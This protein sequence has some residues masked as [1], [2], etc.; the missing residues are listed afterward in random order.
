MLAW[1]LAAATAAPVAANPAD[2]AATHA[3]LAADYV[4]RQALLAVLPQSTAAADAL[5]GKLAGECPGVLAGAPHLELEEQGFPH[6]G[7]LRQRFRQ[8]RQLGHLQTELIFA[9][10]TASAQPQQ[11]AVAA[12]LA[13]VAPLRWSS[14]AVTRGVRAYAA[15]FAQRAEVQGLDVCTDMRAW[16]SSG[17]KQLS[18]ATKGFIVRLQALYSQIEPDPGVVAPAS[19]LLRRYEGP[20]EKA[21]LRKLRAL[22]VAN[23][24]YS[25]VDG[26][27][28]RVRGALGIPVPAFERQE[29]PAKGSVVLGRGRTAAGERFVARLE[30]SRGT[31][32]HSCQLNIS[33][34][35]GR[36]SGGNCLSRGQRSAQPSVNCNGGLLSIESFTRPSTRSVSLLL[37]DGRRITSRAL[38]V[39]ARLGGPAGL[40]YQ[41]VR[42]PSPIPVSLTELDAR[43]RTVRIVKLPAVVE[44]TKHPIKYFPGGIKTLARG[45]TPGGVRFSIVGER[46]RFL[47]HATFD[48]KVRTPRSLGLSGSSSASGAIAGSG[49]PPLFSPEESTGCSPH[50]YDIIYGLLKDPRDT[51]LVRSA[52]KLTALRKVRIPAELR[53]EGVL[54]YGAFSAAPSELIVRGPHGRTLSHESRTEGEGL[55]LEQ[56]ETESEG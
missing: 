6:P 44:C 56:C 4:Y 26:A 37:S 45:T 54:A 1:L 13:A 43:G 28:E 47:G 30:P 38:I 23:N 49:G 24:L 34:E 35:S 50:P 48:L 20:A 3:Y 15:R 25:S 19:P 7:E 27:L 31:I 22:P 12:F 33:I 53:A 16:V 52:G 21:L 55:G 51:V 18:A 2:T 10:Y 39:P 17:Y 14:A 11:P 8:Q 42:G 29:V 5:A 40:Y 32:Q 46:Y 9:I 36:S 41:V